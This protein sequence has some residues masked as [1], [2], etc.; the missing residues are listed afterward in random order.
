MLGIKLFLTMTDFTFHL[1]SNFYISEIANLIKPV[2][3]AIAA[4]IL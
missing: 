4:M 2:A 3:S 1:K